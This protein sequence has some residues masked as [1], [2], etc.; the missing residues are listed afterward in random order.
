MAFSRSGTSE[1]ISFF[2]LAATS[3][4]Q[5]E[6]CSVKAKRLP[7]GAHVIAPLPVRGACVATTSSSDTGRFA[8]ITANGSAASRRTAR[9]HIPSQVKPL[10]LTAYSTASAGTLK[11]L[12]A[13]F[14]M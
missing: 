11:W 3:Y 13:E 2:D 5:M 10:R 14:P 9:R 4:C 12:I 1:T 8:A 6:L 7:S